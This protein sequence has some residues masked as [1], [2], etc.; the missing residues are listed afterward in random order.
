MIFDSIRDCKPN[1]NEELC[2]RHEQFQAITDGLNKTNGF[3]FYFDRTKKEANESNLKV[4]ST[5]LN[6]E[7]KVMC[8]KMWI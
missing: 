6:L 1:E 7:K 3:M 4:E 5:S 2:H 8:S